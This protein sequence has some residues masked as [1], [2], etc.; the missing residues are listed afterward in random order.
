MV[1]AC[2]VRRNG[3]RTTGTGIPTR[4]RLTPRQFSDKEWWWSWN[5]V[6]EHYNGKKRFGTGT[7]RLATSLI[8]TTAST[9]AC[10]E[11]ST[12]SPSLIDISGDTMSMTSA[13]R[14]SP[15]LS[16]GASSSLSRSALASC[17]ATN[18][19]WLTPAVTSCGFKCRPYAQCYA[20]SDP[21]FD[22]AESISFA[23]VACSSSICGFLL[24]CDS[25]CHASDCRYEVS[26]SDGSYMRGKW[27][28]SRCKQWSRSPPHFFLVG[29]NWR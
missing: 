26:Y 19:W 4:E 8:S 12:A 16:S 28:K 25:N 17:H 10:I 9:T 22:S 3:G 21:V 14:W 24:S 27:W 5:A 29:L 23:R 2:M 13:P 6:I 20:Q 1:F 18:T 11:T 7:E 15:T